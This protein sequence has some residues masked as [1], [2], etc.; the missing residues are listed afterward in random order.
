MPAAAPRPISRV[1]IAVATFGILSLFADAFG[2]SPQQVR[3]CRAAPAPIAAP[4]S[5][6]PW[7]A[8][9]YRTAR[10]HND[11]RGCLQ[12]VRE[13]LQQMMAKPPTPAPAPTPAPTPSAAPASSEAPAKDSS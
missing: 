9:A 4:R 3:P 13:K 11:A 2:K 5:A 6:L 10:G 12:K 1:Q 8:A 7:R